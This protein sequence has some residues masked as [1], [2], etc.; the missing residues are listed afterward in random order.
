MIKL[1]L[2]RHGQSVWNA[3]KLFMGWTDVGLTD[4]GVEEAKNAGKLLKEAGF[5]F[6][7]GFTSYLERA[8]RTLDLALG[9][10]GREDLEVRKSWKLNEKSYGALQGLSKVEMTELCGDD[11]VHPWRRSYDV[12]PPIIDDWDPRHPKNDPLYADVPT[13]ELPATESLKDTVERFLEYWSEEIVP[14]LKE[15]SEVVISA[16]GNSL[17]ALVMHLDQ[18]AEDEIPKLNIPTGIPLVYELDEDLKPIKH[19]YLGDAEAAK[20]AAEAVKNQAQA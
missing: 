3:K 7:I 11:T 9:E 19:Y 14:E 1:V 10:M 5:K 8:T 20:A 12:R 17:R 6:D 18:M 4:L 16:H 13:Q 15:G 2:I